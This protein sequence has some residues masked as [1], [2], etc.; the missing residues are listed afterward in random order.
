MGQIIVNRDEMLSRA[1]GRQK[2]WDLLIIG[3]GATGAGIALDAA[4]RNL[5]ILLLEQHDFGKGTSS[6]STKLVHG[7][8]RYLQQGNLPLVREALA[9]RERLFRNA[10]HCVER[11]SFILPSYRWWEKPFYGAG[12]ALYDALARGN[13]RSRILSREQVVE[14]IP[15][16]RRAGL[17]GGVL[18]HDGQFDDTKLLICILRTAAEKGAV[19]LN[20]FRVTGFE[21]RA[22]IAEDV[23]NSEPLRFKARAVV[24]ATGAFVDDVRS[25]TG[26]GGRPI[27]APSQGVH[28]V[29]RP[30]RLPSDA[31][32][33][34]RTPDG[35]VM[36]AIPWL[37]GLV[38]GTTDTPI[39]RA[40]LEPAAMAE[41]VDLILRSSEPY[42]ETKLRRDDVRSV[43]TGIRPLV[44][45]SS[46]AA[47]A[48]LARDHVIRVE[49]SGMLTICGGK[50]TTY[51]RMAE[52]CVDRALE[53][54]G[55]ARKKCV[56]ADLLLSPFASAVGP[57]P[58]LHPNFSY[59]EAE[60]VIS[61]REQMARTVEDVLAR[62]TRILF[63][64]VA[65]ALECAPRVADLMAAELGRDARWR[66]RQIESF[67]ATSRA[68]RLPS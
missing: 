68:Y 36:F 52:E 56:T 8:V 3:G 30:D 59:T 17:R 37:G 25:L 6:R 22:I 42:F 20:Y 64:D 5:S 63:L 61:V 67:I 21:N 18:Y 51:R 11:R 54:A 32:L 19:L 4:S 34:P 27:V 7:G 49:K 41:E 46:N 43:F 57:S 28:L 23:E 45:A 15:A 62:R 39:E 33:V 1:R 48:G 24:N 50:W 38:V 13:D 35:R 40:S 60:V 29:F 58:R 55:I 9:E 2:P 12:L 14:R 44:R 26:N 10:P 31:M 65:A 66:A 16:I 53:F 47:T